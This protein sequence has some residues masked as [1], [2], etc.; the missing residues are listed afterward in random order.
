M[1]YCLLQQSVKKVINYS[2]HRKKKIGR[3]PQRNIL[4]G[5]TL[6]LSGVLFTQITAFCQSHNLS[7]FSLPV[8]DSIIKYY[9]GR[10]ICEVWDDHR[11][12]NLELLKNS[13]IWLSGDGQ[14]DSP[15]YCVQYC[16]YT[17]MDLHTSKIIDFKLV[18]KCMFQGDLERNVCELLLENFTNEEN[19]KMKLFLSD[20]HKGIRYYLQTQHPEIEHEF[21]IWHITKSLMERLK[22][23]EKNHTDVF[24]WKLTTIYGG[25]RKLTKEM[26]KYWLKNFYQFCIIL[27]MNTNG[28]R[29][30]K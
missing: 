3:R 23:L 11:K 20:R 1:L 25:R 21:D 12:K 29:A 9:T 16:T 22:T 14:F 2:D 15:G 26:V 28:K 6:M 5:S 4:I 7:F 27:V 19:M 18:Q 17:T 8:Y 30:E 10:V 24:L 13:D